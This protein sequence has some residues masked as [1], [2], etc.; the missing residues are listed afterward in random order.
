MEKFG[1]S[2]RGESLVSVTVTKESA[3]AACLVINFSL[4]DELV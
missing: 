1:M 4:Y 2:P 3:T